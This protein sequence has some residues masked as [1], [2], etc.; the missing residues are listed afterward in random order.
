MKKKQNVADLRLSCPRVSQEQDVDVP[1]DAVLGVHI[2]GASAEEAQRD[3][4]FHVLAAVDRRR[5]GADDAPSDLPNIWGGAYM[6]REA[7]LVERDYAIFLVE[8]K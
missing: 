4:G 7:F 5:N 3:R 8:G 6:S 2:L 1:P